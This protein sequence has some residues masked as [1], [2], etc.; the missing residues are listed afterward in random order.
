[1]ELTADFCPFLGYWPTKNGSHD[2]DMK[3]EFF[4]LQN[5]S[6]FV[7]LEREFYVDQSLQWN[8]CIA[9]FNLFLGYWLKCFYSVG[10]P[11]VS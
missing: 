10:K 9:D 3:G 7:L 11:F 2:Y 8:L 6:Y 1:M 5:L 4:L